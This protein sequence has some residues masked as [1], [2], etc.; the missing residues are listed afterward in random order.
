MPPARGE[1]RRAQFGQPE[2]QLGLIAGLRRHAAAPPPRR[3]R[4]RRRDAAHRRPDLRRSAPSASASSTASSPPGELLDAAKELVLT[5]ATKAPVA[6]AMTLQALRAADLPL[7]QGLQQ[8]AALFGQCVRD[9]GLRRRRRR[10]PQPPRR[11][12]S[13]GARLRPWAPAAYIAIVLMLGAERVLLGLR[14][15][16]R[17]GQPAQDRG[18]RPPARAGLGTHRA[19]SSWPTRPRS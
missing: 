10:V 12:S 14:D 6:V 16:V 13:R 18:P 3:P 15:R 19:A 11:P 17:D 5:I 7:P 8:E 4:H 1:L 9:G 2:V